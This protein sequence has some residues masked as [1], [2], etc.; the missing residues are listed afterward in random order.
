MKMA[1]LDV[2]TKLL[3][4]DMMK[5]G[6]LR[7]FADTRALAVSRGYTKEGMNGA[8]SDKA[9]VPLQV[10]T[11][12]HPTL[13]RFARALAMTEEKTMKER[14]GTLGPCK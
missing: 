13:T 4:R 11:D 12:F 1:E 5:A 14:T 6:L 8:G 9:L 10:L 3:K 7:D 2:V